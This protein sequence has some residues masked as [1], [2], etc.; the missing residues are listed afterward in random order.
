MTAPGTM[1][2][3]RRLL[4][5]G[6]VV[7][8]LVL[9]GTAAAKPRIKLVAPSAAI[10]P[11]KV[12]H[13]A[14]QLANVRRHS[15]YKVRVRS[16]RIRG[17]RL[18]THLP[19]SF[20]RLR[21]DR[22][23]IVQLRFKG[24]KALADRRYRVVIRGTYKTRPHAGHARRFV[25]RGKV[26]LPP[27]GPGESPVQ[28]VTATPLRV[29]GAPFPPQKPRFEEEEVNGSRWTVPS[30]AFVR[31]T[32]TQDTT[33]LRKAKGAHASRAG[34]VIFR[35]NRGL[36]VT[37]ASS[38]V[39]PTGGVNA[40][41]VVFAAGNWFAA[42]STN[43]GVSFNTVNP[44]TIFPND[45]IGF[46]CDQIIQYVP[47]IDRFIWLLQGTN[48][49]RLASASPATVASSGAT[50]WTYWNL[51]STL[52]GQPS[53]T[54]LD[55][56]DLSVGSNSLFLSWDV[57][58]PACPK[59]CK[60]GLQVNRISLSQIQAGGTI[61]IGF[62]HPEDSAV[63]WGSKLVQDTGDEIFWAGHVS[64]SKMRVYSLQDASNTYFWRDKGISTWANNALSST[65]SDN[66]NWLA[67][68]GGFP[69]NAV[70]GG[71]RSDNHIWFAWDAGTDR[72][73][74]QDHI[75]M[76]DLDRNRNFDKN[77]Q[78]QIWN[79]SFAFAYPALATHPCTGEVGLSLEFG[80]GGNRFQDHAVGFWGDFVVFQ[81]TA[82]NVGTTRFGDY[83]S[84]RNAPATKAD[85]GNLFA[86][87]GYGLVKTPPPQS[88]TQ[89]DIRYVLFG[90]PPLSCQIG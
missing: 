29:K 78:V 61:G 22:P 64:N 67:G 17:L 42:Y 2:H 90:R 87:F 49:Y 8:W 73:F 27:P 48:G 26:V 86:A 5:A 38:I 59:G 40:N 37:N 68:S 28:N 9:P 84:I 23:V 43:N 55:Y 85:P 77:Q 14:G 44:T 47:K 57:G 58:F 36:G 13:V 65:T 10:Q 82:S 32:P 89:T 71:T 19:R 45:A 33:G 20:K 6:A 41:N 35:A 72:N 52:F 25:V 1:V 21:P 51:P 30:G 79:R 56:P 83:V 16:A 60:S 12:L 39:E 53:G 24:R 18:R 74:P 88:Q 63:A 54:G 15:V 3:L 69:G 62:T 7:G 11:A 34:T 4:A 80:G 50:A 70:I 75:E 46:C 66:R 31:G 76:V 81:T